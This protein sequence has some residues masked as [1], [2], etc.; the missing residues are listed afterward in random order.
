MKKI[1]LLIIFI[2]ISNCSLKKV[3]KHHGV[4]NL[5]KK[6]TK[7]RVNQS[8][9]NDILNLIGPPS[10]KSKFDNDLYIYIERKTSSSKLRKLGKKVLLENNV[11]ILDIDSRG[12]LI[13][14]QFYNKEDMNK[15]LFDKNLTTADY[16]KRS[17]IYNFFYSL[18][19]RIDDP[20][21]M[22]R[23]KN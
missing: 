1:Y 2:L 12:I 6:Q 14:K 9:K 3:V 19:Q 17:F 16:S 20:R 13:A 22:K 15:I 23:S 5:E 4:H 21:G 8:N 18:R 7:L 11:L 10:T